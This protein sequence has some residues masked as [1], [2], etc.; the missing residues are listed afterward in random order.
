M[1]VLPKL[2]Y[3]YDALAPTIS[4]TT[5]RTHHDKHHARYV[6]VANE[7]LA[8]TDHPGD[9][10]EEVILK[11]WLRS[12]QKLFNNAA[13]AFNHEFYWSSMSPA[14]TAPSGELARALE[15]AFEGDLRGRFIAEGLNHFGSGWVW[16]V[17][18]GGTLTT[19]ATHDADTVV[20]MSGVTPL[21][22]CDVWEHAYY[23]DRKNDRGAYLEGWWDRLA[24]WAFADR[25]YQA[26][27]GR[28]ARWTYPS[29]DLG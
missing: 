17:S 18:N 4:E 8:T 2:P 21:L 23:L 9:S 22:V 29:G 13:Q 6:E 20:R 25:Q 19:L 16:L 14:P 11:A 28:S 5:L 7:L 15:G 26:S 1:I 10:I 24:N 27:L 12:A 3:A